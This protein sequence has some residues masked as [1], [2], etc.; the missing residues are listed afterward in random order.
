MPTLPFSAPENVT[1]FQK[2]F[3]YANTATGD[4]FGFVV[5]FCVWVI[6]FLTFSR[7][8]PDRAITGASFLAWGSAAILWAFGVSGATVVI[9]MSVVLL[10]SVMYMFA[11]R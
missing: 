9:L 3:Q 7:Y 10:A 4:L 2:L 1:T 6:A 11:R 8:S 5:V